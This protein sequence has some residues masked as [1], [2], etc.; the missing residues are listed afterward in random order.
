MPGRVVRGKT[1]DLEP[2]VTVRGHRR[3]GD[4]TREEVPAAPLGIVYIGE[5]IT[6]RAA[7]A[8]AGVRRRRPGVGCHRHVYSPSAVS[9]RRTHGDLGVGVDG[10]AT[11]GDRGGAE[12]HRA[13]VGRAGAPEEA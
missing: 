2:A 5:L 6:R 10:V 8:A 9:R 4:R 13:D 3:A 11:A 1:G 12:L 7:W